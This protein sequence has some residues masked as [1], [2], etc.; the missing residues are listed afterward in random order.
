MLEKKIKVSVPRENPHICYI[1][2][3]RKD[4]IAKIKKTYNLSLYR[5]L[6][7]VAHTELDTKKSILDFKNA[8]KKQGWRNIGEWATALVD[9]LSDQAEIDLSSVVIG[10]VI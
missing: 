8:L 5:V 1:P 7:T 6:C 2:G 3:D 4:K 9:M 10:D